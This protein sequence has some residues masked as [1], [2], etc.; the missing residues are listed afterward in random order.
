VRGDGLFDA[1]LHGMWTSEITDASRAAD[2]MRAERARGRRQADRFLQAELR[3]GADP[4][5]QVTADTDH[6]LAV[7]IGA[8]TGSTAFPDA[9]LAVLLEDTDPTAAELTVT[10]TD[11][12]LQP[13]QVA[14]VPTRTL[15]LPP[16][17]DAE[18]VQFPIPARS[19]GARLAYRVAVSYRH[20]F[21]QTAVLRATVGDGRAPVFE[22]ETIVRTDSVELATATPHDVE[23]VL[24]HTDE[25][26]ALMSVLADGTPYGAVAAITPEKVLDVLSDVAVVLQ[27][28][29]RK[30]DLFVER[31]A[32][33]AFGELMLELA[34]KGRNL[35]ELF[36]GEFH[37][38]DPAWEPRLRS[39]ARI[40]VLCARPS[41]VAPLEIIYDRPLADDMGGKPPW[42]PD[43]AVHLAA[44]ACPGTCAPA[45]AE[46]V[47][48][49]GFWGVR[50]VIERH[51]PQHEGR[52]RIRTAQAES[53][54]VERHRIP[55]TEVFAAASDRADHNDA[56]AWTSSARLLGGATLVSSW[57]E[58]R[59]KVLRSRRARRPPQVVMLVPHVARRDGAELLEIGEGDALPV[60]GGWAPLVVKRARAA[61][62]SSGDA[63]NPLVMLLG[64]GT[65]GLGR[66]MLAPSTQFLV[67]GAPAV[68]STLAIVLGRDIVPV[69]VA[70]LDELR[71]T[72]LEGGRGSLLGSAML[73][74]RR[75]CLAEGRAAVLALVSFG[76]TD[77]Q[78]VP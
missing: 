6:D 27:R 39:A 1:A 5:E 71:K 49:F 24:N 29:A 78:L 11:L 3:R 17:G 7:W 4:V 31:A 53:P 18:P 2:D 56:A 60:L 38:L 42:C 63:V 44:G 37:L 46:L 14:T 9:L 35:H 43:A 23:L 16:A 32:S 21:L 33:P 12:T 75:R 30:P 66:E 64:C 10:L 45:P 58:L 61:A 68:V 13:G 47:C 70:L 50:K 8:G 57:G 48:P 15:R 72:A 67:G 51:G 34:Q 59:E 26:A 41:A 19:A 36:F 74:A 55:L 76:D 52:R 40:S 62:V 65:A 25:G 77:W 73:A 69:G 28:L 54:D 20:R 22:V